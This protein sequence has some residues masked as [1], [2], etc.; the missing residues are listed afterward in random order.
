MSQNNPRITK[1][2]LALIKGALRR[3]FARSELR[4]AVIRKALV[5]HSDPLRP[6]VKSWALCAV[7]GKP[8]AKSYIVV[9]HKQP[10]IELTASLEEYCLQTLADRIWCIES[11]LQAICPSCHKLKTKLENAQRRK[12]KKESK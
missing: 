6:R 9:D 3:V 2:D 8:E 4:H 10:V 1:K 7:C 11:N 12:Y 5:E